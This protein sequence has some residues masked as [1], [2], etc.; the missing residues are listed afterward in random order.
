MILLS[1][2]VIYCVVQVSDERVVFFDG[3]SYLWV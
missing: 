2:G 3:I 1:V